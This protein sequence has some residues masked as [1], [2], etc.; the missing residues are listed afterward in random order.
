ME[1]FCT[2]SI[3]KYFEILTEI[4]WTTLLLNILS[5]LICTWRGSNIDEFHPVGW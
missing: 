5:I 3:N 4:W 1:H 2:F